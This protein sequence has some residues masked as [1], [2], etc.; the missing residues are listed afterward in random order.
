MSGTNNVTDG[1]AVTQT[2]RVLATWLREDGTWHIVHS[3]FSNAKPK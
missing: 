1:A 3:Q 2:F